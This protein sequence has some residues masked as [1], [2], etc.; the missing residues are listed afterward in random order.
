MNFYFDMIIFS[1]T[2]SRHGRVG[3]LQT[4]R[5]NFTNKKHFLNI[6]FFICGWKNIL[7]NFEQKHGW[8]LRNENEKKW[9]CWSCSE[10]LIWMLRAN[11]CLEKW[12]FQKNTRA[13]EC[14]LAEIK[15]LNFNW[16]KFFLKNSTH[17][18]IWFQ[19]IFKFW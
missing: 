9:K 2:L 10:N 1:K 14:I 17:W 3:F 18:W 15:I 12:N 19:I 16:F 5:L 13:N 6:K 4:R 11:K 7:N 8:N